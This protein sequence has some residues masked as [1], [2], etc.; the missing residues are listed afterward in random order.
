MDGYISNELERTNVFWNVY[1]AS[2]TG[3]LVLV[4]N[5]ESS[6]IKNDKNTISLEGSLSN[7]FKAR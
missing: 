7:Y 3:V 6:S 4:A 1:G 5:N 2:N